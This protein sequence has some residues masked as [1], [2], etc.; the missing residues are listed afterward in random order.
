MHTKA[1]ESGRAEEV[2]K[3]LVDAIYEDLSERTGTGLEYLGEEAK[4]ELKGDWLSLVEGV[5][6]GAGL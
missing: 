3:L 2:A 4:E 6:L 5:L 1:D